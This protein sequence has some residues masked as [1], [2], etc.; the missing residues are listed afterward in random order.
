MFQ[1]TQIAWLS[2]ARDMKDSA[3]NH[4]LSGPSRGQFLLLQPCAIA[5]IHAHF[6]VVFD[7]HSS[8]ASVKMAGCMIGAACTCAQSSFICHKP[9]MD[10]SSP[11]KHLMMCMSNTVLM[12]HCKYVF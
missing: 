8:L 7:F 4:P 2:T 9:F 11:L 6:Y 10:I 3:S 5:S 1:G 12:S